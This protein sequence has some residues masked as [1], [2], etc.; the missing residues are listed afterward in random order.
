MWQVDG[1]DQFASGYVGMGNN[2]VNGTDPDGQWFQY[3][4]GAVLGGFSGYKIGQAQGAKG[5]GLAGYVFGGAVSVGAG[6]AV[7]G[8]TAK[9]GGFASGALGGAAAGAVSGGYMNA[10]AGGSFGRGFTQGAMYGAISGGIFAGVGE[11]IEQT[12]LDS[13]M[14]NPNYMLASGDKTIDLAEVTIYGTR[15]IPRPT[16]PR[17]PWEVGL[18]FAGNTLKALATVPLMT[19]AMVLTPTQLGP[20][21]RPDPFVEDPFRFMA[22]HGKNNGKLSPDELDILKQKRDNGTLSNLEKQKLKRH[23]KNIGDRQSRQSKDK[24]RK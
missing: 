14:R 12:A 19:L 3:A 21:H 22:Q 6:E 2:A 10:L 8:A 17:I 7:L 5:W 18:R 13:Y 24:K 4:I 11:L 16:M 23:E 15:P 9:L 20:A 1:A